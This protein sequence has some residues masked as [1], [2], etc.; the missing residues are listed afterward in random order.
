VVLATDDAVAEDT[1]A[2][3]GRFDLTG[4]SIVVLA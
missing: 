1:T 3:S 2:V 4:R